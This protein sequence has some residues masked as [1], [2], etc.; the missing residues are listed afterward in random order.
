MA[1]R[2][3]RALQKGSCAGPRVSSS[4]SSL[5]FVT[6]ADIVTARTPSPQARLTH[7]N[8]ITLV[9]VAVLISIFKTVKS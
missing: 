9:S 6:A 5:F 3:L 7:N 4:S 8:S 1:D 2:A